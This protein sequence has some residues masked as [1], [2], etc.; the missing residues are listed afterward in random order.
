[1]DIIERIP[2]TN[3]YLKSLIINGNIQRVCIAEMQTSGRG[4][5]NHQ[6]Y[7]PFGQNIYLSLLYF[8]QKKMSELSGLSLIGGLAVCYAIDSMNL[9]DQSVSIKWPNDIVADEKKLSGVLTELQVDSS[10]RISAVIGIGINVNMHEASGNQINQPWTSLKKITGHDQD[11][12]Y[13]CAI[14]I[15]ALLNYLTRFDRFGLK[16]FTDEWQRRDS[17]WN[18]PI[19]LVSHKTRFYGVGAGINLQGHLIVNMPDG[20]LRTFSSGDTVLL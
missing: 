8:F 11:R 4:R 18:K 14:V 6:W 10:G 17:L 19:K 15:D 16:A 13:L 1:M 3:D 2:S 12:N 20:T 7:S 9:L 5:F